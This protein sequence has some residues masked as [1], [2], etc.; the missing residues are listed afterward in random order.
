M[1]MKSY[2]CQSCFAPD[3]DALILQKRLAGFQYD[4]EEYH[5]KH[6]DAFCMEQNIS[7]P[8]ITRE[9][10]MAWG[11]IRATEGKVYCSRRIS[12]LRQLSLYVQS[13]GMEAYIPTHFYKK[14]NSVA[15]VLSDEE[16][17]EF[18]K[19]ADS[20]HPKCKAAAFMRLSM[21]YRILFRIIY[22]CGLRI[23]EARKLRN[24]DVNLSDGSIR[25]AQSKGRKDRI[26]YLV[27][28][29]V[30]LCTWYRN[31]VDSVYHISSI[32]F[33]PARDPK[34]KLSVCTIDLKFRQFWAKTSFAANCDRPP[35]VHSLRHSFV[36]KRMNLW[37]ESGI[38]LNVMMPYLSRYLGHCSPDDTFYY[39][40]QI[41][42]AFRIIRSKDT[43]SS[44]IIPEVS[45]YEE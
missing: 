6:F 20:Y 40:H 36:V 45:T 30:E 28:D 44:R 5:L 32:W 35:T 41:E 24:T 34:C 22:C 33:F 29:L 3:I 14:S 26:V 7:Q 42:E 11:T 8:V 27:P 15:H 18:F 10:V 23:S 21:E 37:M 1:M 19:A 12:A 4:T 2:Q 17:L 13:Q 25:I 16:I 38:A 43:M 39:Y 9:L 31:L